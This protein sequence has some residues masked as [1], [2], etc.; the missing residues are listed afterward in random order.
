M[1]DRPAGVTGHE[2]GDLAADQ[3]HL[4]LDRHVRGVG[5]PLRPLG[6]EAQGA[7]DL[8]RRPLRLNHKTPDQPHNPGSKK[9]DKD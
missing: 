5:T 1:I 8:D 3:R 2:V 4:A 6:G 9:I 7:A